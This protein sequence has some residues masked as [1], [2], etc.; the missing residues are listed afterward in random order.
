MKPA[1]MRHLSLFFYCWIGLLAAAGAANVQVQ[2]QDGSGKPLADAAVFLESGDAGRARSVARPLAGAEMAQVARQFEPRVLVVPLGTS[3]QF[4]N[5][6]KVRHHVYSFSAAKNFELKLYTG[7][8][9]NPVIFDKTGIA[10]LGCNIHDNMVAWIVVVDT[11][12]FGLSAGPGRALMNNVPAGAY[13]LR[14]WHPALPPGA[15]AL[16]QPLL[17]DTVDTVV[18]VRMPG[19]TP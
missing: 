7:T 14:I 9:S 2:V 10:V 19:L 15:P 17:V 11:P 1:L 5:R 18:T 13:H 6:D 4:P 12:Y 8:P 3:V 16:D